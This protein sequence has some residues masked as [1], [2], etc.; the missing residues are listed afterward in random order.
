M[1]LSD[2]YG[3]GDAYQNQT[4]TKSNEEECKFTT[5]EFHFFL[6][7]AQPAATPAASRGIGACHTSN[8]I[9]FQALSLQATQVSNVGNPS[10]CVQ[11]KFQVRGGRAD[12]KSCEILI[13]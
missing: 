2:P 1:H 4:Y 9:R 5:F 13:R 12:M 10:S 7:S 6:I 8:I 3:S 11:P